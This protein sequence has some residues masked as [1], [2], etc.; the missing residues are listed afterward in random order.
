MNAALRRVAVFVLLLFLALFLNANYLQ[1]VRANDLRSRQDNARVLFDEY[2]RQRGPILISNHGVASSVATNDRL[3]YLRR[4]SA[5][6]LY[7]P[8][9]GF[10]SIVYGATG[11][12]QA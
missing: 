3:K 10:Y 5:G 9:T 2:S 4:Y 12:E 1:V 11:I 8:V 7:A 6:P